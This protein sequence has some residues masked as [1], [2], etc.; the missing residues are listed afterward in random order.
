MSHSA[1]ITK[2][3]DV[4][5]HSNADRLQVGECFG[6]QVI[7][8][9]DVKGGDF[10]IYFPSDSQIGSEYCEVNNLLRKK[11]ADGKNVGGYLD[12][13]KR[14]IRALKLRG[15]IS[16]GLFMPLKSLSSITKIDKLKDGDLITVL[17]G[18]EICKK[19]V[20]P[21][22]QQSQNSSTSKK[23]KDQTISYLTFAQHR[24][25][26]QL[27]YNKH[28]FKEGDVCYIT[29]KM[30]GTS[31]RTSNALKA[32]K[33]YKKGINYLISKLFKKLPYKEFKNWEYV[34]GSRRVVLKDYDGGFYGSNQFR[35]QHHDKFESKL[36]KG[37]TV[38]YEIVGYQ[39]KD[40]PIMGTVSNKKTN[41]KE[42]IKKYG[43]TTVYSYGCENGESDI[44]MYR[45]S[46]TNED[47]VEIDY[48]RDLVKL[49][50][51][52]MGEKCTPE[53]DR[54]IFTTIE[55]LNERVSKY[56]DGEDPIGKTHIREG[57]VV[58]IEGKEKFKAF[59]QKNFNF[60]QLEGIIKDSGV[61][62]MEEEESAK[63]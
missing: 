59:K 44:Y 55:D 8:S 41:D 12:P 48:P 45:M 42:F 5:K 50:A 52:Q 24:D 27:A 33:K 19:Y 57:V 28:A 47:G 39:N 38:Y 22:K 11:D 13:N 23:T 14:N 37:E 51:D 4:K 34:S 30:H 26:G 18:I 9:L 25:T 20:P 62:D 15:E 1:Y 16:D 6:N 21:I 31:A 7:V 3:K 60:K 58:I 46:T 2:I 32:E 35:R 36:N 61:V 43:E 63:I 49:R 56:E 10:G 53:L 29:L 54:F 40:R 17:N